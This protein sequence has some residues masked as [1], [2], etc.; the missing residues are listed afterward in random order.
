[1]FIRHLESHF[2]KYPHQEVTMNVNQQKKPIISHQPIS[3]TKFIFVLYTEDSTI[4]KHLHICFILHLDTHYYHWFTKPKESGVWGQKV[5][6]AVPSPLPHT[7]SPPAPP[8]SFPMIPHGERGIREG[9]VGSG[10]DTPPTHQRPLDPTF[11]IYQL[12]TSPHGEWGIREGGVGSSE[13][14]PS[15]HQRLL[16]PTFPVYQLFNFP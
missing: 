14:T 9:G 4:H 7:K 6:E 15:T 8:S 16:D 5:R 3:K 13:N 10:A 1:M 12:S 11:P 2:L